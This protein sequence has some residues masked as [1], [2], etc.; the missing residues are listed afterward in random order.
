MWRVLTA[1]LKQTPLILSAA[2]AVLARSRQ[3]QGGATGDLET[4]RQRVAGLEQQAVANAELSRQLAEHAAAVTTAAQAT[5]A[6]A[7]QAFVLAISSAV[8]AAAALLFAWFR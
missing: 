4:L 3:R 6:K 8:L 7:R 2:D 1:V 5:A